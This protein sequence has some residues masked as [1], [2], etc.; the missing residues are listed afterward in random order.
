MTILAGLSRLNS[1][2]NAAQAGSDAFQVFSRG[3]SRYETPQDQKG[4]QT[5][6]RG[7]PKQAKSQSIP[8]QGKF[9][10]QS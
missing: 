8:I 5:P 3:V 7:E 9:F 2:K 4:M 6:T 10:F 1:K